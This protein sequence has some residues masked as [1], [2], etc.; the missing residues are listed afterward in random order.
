MP[1]SSEMLQI[2]FSF[3]CILFLFLFSTSYEKLSCFPFTFFFPLKFPQI[4]RERLSYF[5]FGT[6]YTD[7]TD[8]INSEIRVIRA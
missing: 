3:L 4:V 6:D 5:L 1:P 7:I 2:D 8:K